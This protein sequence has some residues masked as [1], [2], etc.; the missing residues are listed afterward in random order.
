MAGPDHLII[1]I[2]IQLGLRSEELFALRRDDVNGDMLRIDEA[3]VE[4]ASAPVKT[5]AS[6]ASVYV[7]PALRFGLHRCLEQI[8]PDPRI[9]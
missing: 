5:Q 2:L 7:P 9:L 1:R 3:I 8:R 4:G 6:D